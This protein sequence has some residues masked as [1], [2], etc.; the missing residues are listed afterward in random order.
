MSLGNF[1]VFKCVFL[2]IIMLICSLY[3]V[4]YGVFLEFFVR[5]HD[6]LKF[7]ILIVKVVLIGV[8][9]SS[10]AYPNTD[11]TILGWIKI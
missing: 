11:G 8:L 1:S 4:P 2:D 5:E 6:F 3:V 7:F 10:A 9:G